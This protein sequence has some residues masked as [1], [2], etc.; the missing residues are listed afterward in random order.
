M[1]GEYKIGDVVL[2]NWKLVKL[3]GQG[4]YGKVFEAHREDFGTVYKAAIKIM[5]IP[6][7]QS[8]IA[9]ARAEGMDDES[10]TTYFRSFVGDMVQEFALMSKLKGTAN[11][12]SYEDHSVTPHTRGIGWDMLIRM[13]LLTPMLTYMGSHAMMRNDVIKLGIDM[14]KALELCQRYNII[15]RD[16]KPE[17][18]FIS[19]SGDYKLGDF[20]VARTLEKTQGG[21]SKKGTYTYMAPEVYRDE[22]YGSTVDIYSLGIVLYRLL[23]NNRAPFLPAPPQPITH[24]ERE[25]A[26]IRRINGELLPPPVNAGTRLSEIVLKAC[27]YDPKDRYTSPMQ[28]R[29]EL[30]AIQYNRKDDLAIYGKANPIS[31][32]SGAYTKNQEGESD[33]TATVFIPQNEGLKPGKKPVTIL[34]LDDVTEKITLEKPLKEASPAAVKDISSPQPDTSQ[35]PQRKKKARL[36]AGI[37]VAMVALITLL[38]ILLP[39]ESKDTIFVQTVEQHFSPATVTEQPAQQPSVGTMAAGQSFESPAGATSKAE[40][41]SVPAKQSEDPTPSAPSLDIVE[42]A[43]A[44]T[45]ETW[46]Q[47][48]IQIQGEDLQVLSVRYLGGPEIEKIQFYSWGGVNGGCELDTYYVD[49]TEITAIVAGAYF[50]GPISDEDIEMYRPFALK[51]LQNMDVPLGAKNPIAMNYGP[52]LASDMTQSD[53]SD[54]LLWYGVNRKGEL[55]SVII[56]EV[57]VPVE[58]Y[59]ISPAT[60]GPGMDAQP[61]GTVRG[62][63]TASSIALREGPGVTY[64]S[65]A[66]YSEGELVYIY[67]QEADYYYVQVPDT[68]LKGYMP[69]QFI[70]AEGTVPNMV[71]NAAFIVDAKDSL[72]KLGDPIQLIGTVIWQSDAK[73]DKYAE[74]KKEYQ[75]YDISDNTVFVFDEPF[76]F[77]DDRD[78]IV[79]IEGVIVPSND[80]EGYRN[81]HVSIQGKVYYLSDESFQTGVYGPYKPDGYTGPGLISWNEYG[82][83]MLSVIQINKLSNEEAAH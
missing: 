46:R 2:G 15:H 64:K 30:E 10:I 81:A 19:D 13:E 71:L 51:Y 79:T 21:L 6:E 25:R 1:N 41:T 23:N 73:F 4:A 17:N 68:E 42:T 45:N 75:G 27:A 28:M 33:A 63:I 18:I 49:N 66:Q 38:T 35:P 78:R 53:N 56:V 29:Q 57:G 5:T 12:V 76:S 70:T 48:P 77:V 32:D 8:E 7:S 55:V 24:S 65:F 44:D 52:I 14:C 36:F 69:A 43:T 39:K 47:L 9:N 61:E 20:G 72:P 59:N 40:A 50:G 83:Y 67:Y 37:A 31:V 22:K 80:V 26:L 16:I 54:F 34:N 74:I 82:P 58:D 11:I 3:L 62:I 60:V